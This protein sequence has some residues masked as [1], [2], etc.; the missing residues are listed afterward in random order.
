MLLTSTRRRLLKAGLLLSL[1]LTS[2]P[3]APGYAAADGAAGAVY[4]LTN[5][6]AGNSVLA[7][8]PRAH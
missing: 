4:A 1:T 3:A 5:A 7:Y 2:M 8:A 6:P